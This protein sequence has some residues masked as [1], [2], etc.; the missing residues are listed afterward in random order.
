MS[1]W[2]VQGADSNGASQLAA[3]G[4]KQSRASRVPK[5]TRTATKDERQLVQKLWRAR[6]AGKLSVE[7]EAELAAMS[8]HEAELA[9]TSANDSLMH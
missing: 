6:G 1:K 4:A 8:A 5:N 3:P 2:K 7:E 9:A